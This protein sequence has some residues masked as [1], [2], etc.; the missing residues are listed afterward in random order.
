MNY[1]IGYLIVLFF[2]GSGLMALLF[3]S[4]RRFPAYP[5]LTNIILMLISLFIIFMGLEFYLKVFFAEPHAMDTLARQNW[6]ERYANPESYNSSGYRDIQWTEQM[7]AGKTK[8][9]I[10]GDSFVFG[11]GIENVQDRFSDRLGQMLGSDYVVFNLGRGGT[12]TKHHIEAMVQYPYSPDIL[13]LSYFLNDIQGAALEHQWTRRPKN[14]EVTPWAAPLVNNSYA[15]NFL[16]W[17]LY[18]LVQARQPDLSWDWYLQLYND[19]DSWWVYKQQLLSICE[20]AKAE[21][22]P[23]VVVV[24]PS[25]NHVAESQGVNER[26]ISLFQEK[27]IPVL[28]V[29]DFIT[30]IPTEALVASSMDAHPSEL[31]HQL[32]ADHLYELLIAEYL[33]KPV[34][35]DP[36]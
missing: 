23:L 2:V 12:N 16:Y 5:F 3:Y 9:M 13:I 30:G 32:V 15:L 7:V 35:A 28:D 27:G 29:A 21:E 33:V 34:Q 26:I 6:R 4:H 1:W 25:M 24:F 19:P 14:P 31:V 10:V 36:N 22:I 18:T 11:D 8:I 17:R 20:G